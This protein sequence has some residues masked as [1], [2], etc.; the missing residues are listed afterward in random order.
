MKKTFVF[1][2]ELLILCA[3]TFPD[4]IGQ[5]TISFP[6]K[7]RI[8]ADLYGPAYYY[9]DKNTFTI[10]GFFSIDRDTLKSWSFDAGYSRFEFEQYN[11]HYN[12]KGVFLCS[13]IEFNVISPESSRG[14]YF[15]GAG[16]KYG[17][18]YYTHEI[19]FL[20]SEN[21]W[22]NVNISVKPS[23]Q[24]AH[25]IEASPGIRTEIFSNLSIGWTIRLRILIYSGTDR[26]MKSVYIP[27]YG[28]GTKSFSPGINYYLVW[29]IP[30]KYLKLRKRNH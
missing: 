7:I 24:L 20:K 14:K 3:M 12:C 25:F 27:G 1:F 18:S 16:L 2:T 30:Y 11:Y 19:P 6:L 13:G 9:A 15:A 26:D 10:E 23:S 4:A 29:S 28:N 22:G 8:G 21:Y 17:M 5:D